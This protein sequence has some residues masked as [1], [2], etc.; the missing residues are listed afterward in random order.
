MVIYLTT[1]SASFSFFLF[2]QNFTAGTDFPYKKYTLRS[3]KLRNPKESRRSIGDI[4]RLF[5]QN[6]D[7]TPHLL[8]RRG[9]RKYYQHFHANKRIIYRKRPIRKKYRLLRFPRN[10][11]QTT[12]LVFKVVYSNILFLS[13]SYIY[14][15]C[16][17]YTRFF[18][19]N[20]YWRPRRDFDSVTRIQFHISNLLITTVF[21]RLLRQ[22]NQ[23]SIRSWVERFLHDRD[24]FINSSSRLILFLKFLF[25]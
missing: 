18:E 6:L 8:R 21:I 12:H 3:A 9:Q 10:I 22:T 25:R 15:H 7:G 17:Q 2:L 16:N 23:T 19:Y 13:L 5:T 4:Q 14:I 1:S 24:S 20:Q 11:L